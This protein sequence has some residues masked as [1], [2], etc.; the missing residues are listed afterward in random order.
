MYISTITLDETVDLM[1][2]SGDGGSRFN[3]IL[4]SLNQAFCSEA[5]EAIGVLRKLS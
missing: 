3:P 4:E 2:F 5:P 1:V